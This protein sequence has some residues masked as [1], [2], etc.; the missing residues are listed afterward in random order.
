MMRNSFD[1][2]SDLISILV[3]IFIQIVFFIYRFANQY[4]NM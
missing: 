2:Y 3:Y 4:L 1:D